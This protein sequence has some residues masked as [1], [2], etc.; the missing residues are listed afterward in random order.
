MKSRT[1]ALIVAFL[2]VELALFVAIY[3]TLKDG[4]VI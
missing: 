2:A 1:V 4:G 3:C